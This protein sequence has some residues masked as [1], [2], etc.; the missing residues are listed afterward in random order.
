[1]SLY[2]QLK[3]LYDQGLYSN[4]ATLA[5]MILTVGENTPEMLTFTMKYQTLVYYADSLVSLKEYKKAESLYRKALQL[6]KSLAKNKGKTQPFPQ[7]EVTSEVDVKFKAHQCLVNLKQYPQAIALL[8]TISAKQRTPSV[9][10]ALAKLYHQNGMERS[11]I[12]SYKEVLKECPFAVEAAEGLLT[13]GVKVTEVI[14]LMFSGPVNV[15]NIDWLSIWIRGQAHFHS[16]ELLQAISLFKQLD[17]KSPLRDNLDVL[18]ALGE[19]YYYHGDYQNALCFLERAYCSDPLSVKGMDVYAALLAKEKKL[20]ELESLTAHLISINDAVPEPWI[21]MAYFCYATKK[22]TKAVNFAQKACVLN[23]RHVEALLLKGTVLLELKRIQDAISNFV[24]ASK[25]APY[26]YEVHKGMVDG[27]LALHRTREAIVVASTACKQL[28]QNARALTLYA[29]VLMKDPLNTVKAKAKSLLEKALKQ[30][31]TYLNAVYLLAAIY[32][33]ERL[34]EKGIELL[35][36]QMEQQTSCRLHQ[37]LGDFLART[38]EHEKALHHFSIALN[39]DPSNRKAVEGSQRV[40]QNPES[41]ESFEVDDI[42]DSE[43]E[44]DLEESEVE[45]VWSDA[46]YT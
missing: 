42:P 37:M 2:D 26:R 5:S 12:T 27:Y 1:M 19:A 31:P 3:L 40:E 10:M 45:A 38:N 25:I 46:D 16:R 30:D 43:N 21:A 32:E 8:E 41:S 39:M 28:G 29:S 7:G 11:A 36:R 17:M 20:K 15:V 4:V 18:I 14:A 22:G 9:N 35:K 24:E 34:Y 44:G 13:L 33:Q 6:K 23:P